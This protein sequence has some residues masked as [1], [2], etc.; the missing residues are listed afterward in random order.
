MELQCPMCG[1]HAVKGSC[2]GC[3]LWFCEEHMYRHRQ[4]SHGK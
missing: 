2:D 4:C 3:N 1:S